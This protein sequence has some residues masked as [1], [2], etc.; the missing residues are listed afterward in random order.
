MKIHYLCH[1][2]NHYMKLK[3]NALL[4]LL[5]L[6]AALP[7]FAQNPAVYKKLNNQYDGVIYKMVLPG[8]E[9]KE[10]YYLVW[11]NKTGTN[12][13]GFCDQNGNVIFDTKYDYAAFAVN[14]W[15]L[16]TG[17]TVEIYDVNRQLVHTVKGYPCAK[18]YDRAN[19]RVVVGHEGTDATFGVIDFDG[20]TIIPQKYRSVSNLFVENPNY[21][22]PMRLFAIYDKG[23]GHVGFADMNGKVLINPE[24]DSYTCGIELELKKGR[25]TGVAATDGKL[26][27][28][29]EKYTS[30]SAPLDSEG[31]R[32]AYI[33]DDATVLDA[34]GKELMPAKYTDIYTDDIA[35]G[36]RFIKVKS[37]DKQGYYSFADGE[38]VPPIYDEAYCHSIDDAPAVFFVSSGRNAGAIDLKGNIIVPIEYPFIRLEPHGGIYVG[39]CYST[40]V[41]RGQIMLTDVPAGTTW[42][43]YDLQGNKI[44]PAEYAFVGE[45]DGLLLVNRGGNA[46]AFQYVQQRNSV[47][48][49]LWGYMDMAGNEVVPVEY[50]A[51]GAFANGVANGVKNGVAQAVKHPGKGTSLKI[52]NGGTASFTSP[53]DRNIPKA[54]KPDPELFAFIFATENYNS[55]KGADYALR[56]GETFRQYCES[57]LG[58]P[59][60]NVRM[61]PDATFGNIKSNLKKI[62]EIAEVYDGDA[63]F[64]IY[65]AG[66]GTVDGST[67]TPYLL[68][69]DAVPSAVQQTAI[70][71]HA[72]T[73]DLEQ[74]AAKWTLLL[75][76]APTNGN[77]RLGK[78]LG[79]GRG[80]RFA[81]KPPQPKGA[82]FVCTA[83]SGDSNA[84]VDATSGHGLLTLSF[85]EHLQQNPTP[86]S[87]ADRLES[88]AGTVKKRSLDAGGDIQSPDIK[89]GTHPSATSAKL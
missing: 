21:T 2:I 51:L 50:E 53:V 45:C 15:Y 65:F 73:A 69:S 68:P 70:D 46:P 9:I 88:V 3:P 14:Y 12:K 48:G 1:K 29:A 42:G 66:L 20:K 39:V 77:D 89:I 87:I 22:I 56:D 71:L 24:Y 31:R 76:D 57:A 6:M 27:V 38:V 10:D 83:A 32:M 58:V 62:A 33:D 80:V 8:D 55:F 37:G 64:I 44:L 47:S 25:Y 13:Y 7:A 23:T 49:G 35:K 82:V 86:Q 79:E 54:A 4:S 63:K 85:L 28:K 40:A 19:K 61:F 60:K 43:Y 75:V 36:H 78:P 30:L 5:L 16:G 81:P 34:K 59:A 72:L 18:Y 17:N 67:G 74:V 26:L 84:A 52:L 11:N 41:D